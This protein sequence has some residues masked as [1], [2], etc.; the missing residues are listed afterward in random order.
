MQNI[1]VDKPYRFI[2]PHRGRMWPT[3]IQRLKLYEGYLRKREGVVGYECRHVER[4]RASLDQGHG[5]LLAPNHCRTADPVV[6][7]WLADE[8]DALLYAMASWHLFNQ[9]RWMGWA[10]R[11][12]GAFSVNREGVDRQAINAA[13]EILEKAE[14]PLVVFPEGGVSRTND[15]LHALLDISL[16]PRAAAR[17]RARRDGGRVVVHP[18]AIKYRFGGDL[19]RQAD[20]VLSDIEH[21]LSWRPQR[22]LSLIPRIAKVGTALLCLKEI[23]YLGRVQ[24]G[25]LAERL[26]GLIDRL[27]C[28]LEE[29]WLGQAHAGPVVPRVKALRVKILP[30]LVE[31]RVDDNERR[32]RLEQLEDLYLAQQIA[33]YP[34]DY[35]EA[36]PSVDRLLE[37]IERFEEDLTGKVTVHGSLRAII[38]VGEAIEVA[39]E[40][41]RTADVDPLMGQIERALQDML[42]A[43]ARESPLYEAEGRR[44]CAG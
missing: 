25:S 35:L 21:R 2:P 29:Q 31:G 1:V 34:P 23:E 9:S 28:P 18:V 12:M 14:R 42:D 40:R 38:D 8:A 20:K 16:I 22:P 24:Q 33:C 43:L 13:I 5:I 6:M 19:D 36:Y 44:R 15:R 17:R 27:L 4:L 37:T 30:D 41:D 32:R 7:G 39:P 3:L 10:I 26:Q 11:R